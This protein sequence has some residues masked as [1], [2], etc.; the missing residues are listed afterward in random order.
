[1]MIGSN[2]MN[3]RLIEL[4]ENSNVSLLA[5]DYDR[6]SPPELVFGL[7]WEL[8][9]EV[10]NGPFGGRQATSRHRAHSIG[11]NGETPSGAHFEI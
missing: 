2:E 8:E 10:N 11:A 3:R 4:S 1:M 7:V 6:I 5:G 9:S